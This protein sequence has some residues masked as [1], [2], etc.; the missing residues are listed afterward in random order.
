MG[1]AAYWLSRQERV[2]VE[3]VIHAN[4]H[5]RYSAPVFRIR[6]SDG[7]F[8]EVERSDILLQEEERLIDELAQI[9]YHSSLKAQ[10]HRYAE[11]M[12]Y[13]LAQ[14]VPYVHRLR[15]KKPEQE[16]QAVMDLFD[17]G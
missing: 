12:R 17:A 6:R 10:H 5:Q 2:E 16:N 14:G 7:T 3:S 13:F 8:A 15:L 1:A 9:L 4:P 11:L